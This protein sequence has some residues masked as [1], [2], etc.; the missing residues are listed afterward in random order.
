MHNSVLLFHPHLQEADALRCLTYHDLVLVPN[1]PYLT[2]VGEG[3]DAWRRR[4][5]VYRSSSGA[6]ANYV[7]C[8][9]TGHHYVDVRG[10]LDVNIQVFIHS[11]LAAADL[12]R[13]VLMS[14]IVE[15]VESATDAYSK[16]DFATGLC[17]GT[18]TATPEVVGAWTKLMEDE[19]VRVAV[20]ERLAYR[21]MPEIAELVGAFADR[22]TDPARKAHLDQFARI[23]RTLVEIGPGDAALARFAGE[24]LSPYNRQLLQIG[25]PGARFYSPDDGASA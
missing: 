25:A 8:A 1:G 15:A 12:P 9:L 11:A 18:L 7:R 13:V 10:P 4:V 16:I 24:E 17:I 21:T 20:A 5:R 2:L 23:Y 19:Q 22:E 3:E 6:A 14:Q